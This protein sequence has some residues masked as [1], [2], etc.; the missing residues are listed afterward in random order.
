MLSV[1]DFMDLSENSCNKQ[2][3]YLLVQEP[4]EIVVMLLTTVGSQSC[5]NM[6]TR[7]CGMVLTLQEIEMDEKGCVFWQCWGQHYSRTIPSTKF[8][9]ISYPRTVHT[10]A[11]EK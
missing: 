3:S 8:Y 5:V 7:L 4:L 6:D 11:S 2:P 1:E 9:K 10:S